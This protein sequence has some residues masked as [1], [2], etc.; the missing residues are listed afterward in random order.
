METT[1]LKNQ[2][3][4]SIFFVIILLS[5]FCFLLSAMPAFA[6]NLKPD[7]KPEVLPGQPGACDVNAAVIFLKKVIDFM[8]TYTLIPLAALFIVYGGFVILTSAGSEQ[9]FSEGK[10]IITAAVIG[11][12]IALGSY[13]IVNTILNFFIRGTLF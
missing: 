1:S 6:Q 8:L 2:K 3:L 5:T 12:A 10:K 11:T 4:A 9:K 7:C 13:L